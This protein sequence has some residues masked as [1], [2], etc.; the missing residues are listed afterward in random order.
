MSSAR[1]LLRLKT[2]QSLRCRFRL[3]LDDSRTA[4][5]VGAK[6]KVSLP[7]YHALNGRRQAGRPAPFVSPPSIRPHHLAGEVL[8]Q[9]RANHD[10]L[11]RGGR[12]IPVAALLGGDPP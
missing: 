11:V 2:I 5:F 7:R 6:R 3:G 8:T 12:E 1:S 4:I 9:D 10:A